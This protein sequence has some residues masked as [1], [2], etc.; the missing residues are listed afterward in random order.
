MSCLLQA[1]F[2]AFA[3]GNYPYPSSYM[4]GDP[5]HPLPAWPMQVACMKFTKVCKGLCVFKAKRLVSFR[6]DR[7]LLGLVL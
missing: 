6:E 1:A 2:D 5:D 7:V 3:M 4:N